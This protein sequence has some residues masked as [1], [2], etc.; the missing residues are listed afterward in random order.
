MMFWR[1][2]AQEPGARVQAEDGSRIELAVDG[3]LCGL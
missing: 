1:R 2:L 3:L